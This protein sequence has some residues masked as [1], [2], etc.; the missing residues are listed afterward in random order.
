LSKGK[1]IILEGPEGSG[2]TTQIRHL[3]RCLEEEGL[4]VIRVREPGQTDIGERIRSILLDANHSKMTVGTELLLYM[5]SR[6][7]LVHEIVFP[8]L[9]QGTTVLADRF[10]TST[11]VY[12]GIAGELGS[13]DVKR[14]YRLVCGDLWPD[15]VIIL[16]LPAEKGLER[17]RGKKH[18]RVGEQLVGG[19]FDD[20]IEGKPLEFHNRVREGYLAIAKAE[21]DR[22]AVVDASQSEVQV[23][24]AVWQEV[25]RRVLS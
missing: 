18:A 25:K 1:F 12:Q 17:I 13:E 8:A 9:D 16:D 6:V 10:L 4:T 2:K 7:Q 24:K 11:I 20:R 14:L 15:L 19:L 3:K 22:Y 23:A 21:P 5:A